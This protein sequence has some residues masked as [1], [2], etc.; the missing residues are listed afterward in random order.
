MILSRCCWD[1]LYSTETQARLAQSVGHQTFNL[2]VA[3]SCPS[4]GEDGLQYKN[5]S[6]R[7]C[8]HNGPHNGATSP[9]PSEAD[10]M[11]PKATGLETHTG[12]HTIRHR[13]RNAGKFAVS[14]QNSN[15]GSYQH[16]QRAIFTLR[17]RLQTKSNT[18]PRSTKI[19]QIILD[20]QQQMN[21]DE[22]PT[23]S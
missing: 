11:L 12:T 18:N 3:G 19:L 10:P 16:L 4:S 13:R 14:Q 6:C 8:S 22:L 5:M 2:G 9:K 15:K 20:Y 23:I 7:P 21:S 17:D 1:V